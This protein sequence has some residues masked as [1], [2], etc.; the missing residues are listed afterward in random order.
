MTKLKIIVGLLFGFQKAF[1]TLTLSCIL[2][3]IV[4]LC[5]ILITKKQ[6][7]EGI[8]FIPIVSVSSILII[9]FNVN[10]MNILQ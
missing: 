3:S 5:I 1:L 8:P 4:G 9:I 6:L 7:Q 2:G 10:F